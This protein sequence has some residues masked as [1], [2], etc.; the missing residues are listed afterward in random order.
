MNQCYLHACN[1]GYLDNLYDITRSKDGGVKLN[2]TPVG[3]ECNDSLS[4]SI[5]THKSALY[6]M[7]ARGAGHAFNL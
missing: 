2:S 3:G 1:S 7:Y 5:R 6:H 4:Y